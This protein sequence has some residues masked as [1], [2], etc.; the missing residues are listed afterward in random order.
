MKQHFGEDLTILQLDDYF[1]K[2][3]EVPIYEGHH[4]WDAPESLRWEDF[5]KDA[6]NLKAGHPVTIRTK[7]RLYNPDYDRTNAKV[8][9]TLSPAPIL[10]LKGYLLLHHPQVRSHIGTSL[11]LDLDT[12]TRHSRR[13]ARDTDG[14][15]RA[16]FNAVLE[17]MNILHVMPTR[18]YATHVIEVA[19]LA[20]E[21]V[22]AQA[23]SLLVPKPMV[24]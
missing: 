13:E 8:E 16:Y 10:L 24:P 14:L 9:V 15:G 5:V 3:E 19:S 6:E 7:N 22:F 11:F 21:Q 23:L 20:P 2:K 4:N 17:P 1:R 12:P 18:E